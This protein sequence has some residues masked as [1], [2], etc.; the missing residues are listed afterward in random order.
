MRPILFAGEKRQLNFRG[1]LKWTPPA[2]GV[3]GLLF[4]LV[5]AASLKFQRTPVLV[6]DW[7]VSEF[8]PAIDRAGRINGIAVAW[9]DDRSVLVSSDTGGLF[10]SSDGAESFSHV[11]A[12]PAINLSDVKYVT[13]DGSGIVVTAEKDFGSPDSAGAWYSSD[14]GASW[15]HLPD[16]P[17]VPSQPRP[18]RALGISGDPGSRIFLGTS[19]G[20][21]TSDDGGATWTHRNVFTLPGQDPLVACVGSLG[22]GVMVA[23]GIAGVAR[24][25]DNGVTWSPIAQTDIGPVFSNH[26]IDGDSEISALIGADDKLRISQDAGLTWQGID[27]FRLPGTSAGGREFVKIH[28]IGFDEVDVYFGDRLSLLRARGRRTAPGGRFD[29]PDPPAVMA[30]PHADTRAFAVNHLNVPYLL[31]T[32]GGL[33]KTRDGGATWPLTAG[34]QHGLSALQVTE[35]A[36][37]R[38]VGSGRQDLYFLTQDNDLWSSPDNGAHW[39]MGERFEGF[40]FECLPWVASDASSKLVYTACF[41]CLNRSSGP[42]FSNPIDWTNP[43]GV[44]STSPAILGANSYVQ[45][46]VSGPFGA[47]MSV[48]DN[49]GAT[50]RQL[51]PYSEFPFGLPKVVAGAVTTIYQPVRAGAASDG[52][53][54]VQLIRITRGGD[55]SAHGR[56]PRMSGFGGFGVTST[57]FAQYEQVAVD[58]GNALHLIAVDATD[59]RIKQSINGGEDWTEIPH[60]ASMILARGGVQFTPF[61]SMGASRRATIATR[62]SFCP[63]NPQFILLGTAQ[64]GIFSSS[65]GGNNWQAVPGS[66]MAKPVT[67][68]YW[69]NWNDVIVGTY[70]RGIWRMHGAM[71]LNWQSHYSLTTNVIPVNVE[72]IQ[73]AAPIAHLMFGGGL[74]GAEMNDGRLTKLYVEPG[75]STLIACDDPKGGRDVEIV[76][77]RKD[78]GYLGFKER[79]KPPKDGWVAV[80]IRLDPKEGATVLFAPAPMDFPGVRD[81]TIYE[82][83]KEAFASRVASIPYLTVHQVGEVEKSK[84]VSDGHFEVG[85]VVIVQGNRFSPDEELI[86]K[87][88]GIQIKAAPKWSKDTFEF[89]IFAPKDVGAHT[90]SVLQK[91]KQG[92]HFDAA[93]F[94][95]VNQDPHEEGHD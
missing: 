4:I 39:T 34:C 33:H 68:F 52:M 71:R 47:G 73:T 92:D 56:L 3:L 59:R 22:G 27:N 79:P 32:D 80:G 41:G 42:L 82:A 25:I 95:V 48:T 44:A 36:G 93:P 29:F 14:A 74:M 15:S 30:L 10:V 40:N 37:Q 31:A 58:P 64:S 60:L 62:I 12:L 28:R 49:F 69:R 66:E 88:D 57:M 70:G 86:V 75:T 21:S 61:G 26:G 13:P 54:L 51:L 46:T 38:V 53:P 18:M 5:G 72:S 43:A 55:G 77:A 9:R 50:W 87:L 24:S 16:P 35:V 6:T 85:E 8:Q 84:Q 76:E 83:P 78:A 19:R 67:S 63:M 23:G 91:A 11:D 45:G 65:D 90:V 81:E 17:D 7:T 20:V 94:I 1:V 89:R 2:L